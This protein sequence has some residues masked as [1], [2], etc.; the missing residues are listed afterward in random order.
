MKNINIQFKVSFLF[1]LVL[2]F[3]GCNEDLKYD[4]EVLEVPIITDFSPK[5][6]IAGTEIKITGENLLKIDTIYIGGELS[7]I[8][9]RINSRGLIAEATNKSKT[10]TIKIKGP[11]GEAKS[12]ETFQVEYQTPT[13]GE[14]PT[15]AQQNEEI[16]IE[17]THLTA[18]LD[19]FFGTTESKIVNQGIDYITVIVPFFEEDKVDIIMT[20]N[21]AEGV[22]E[23]STEG[24]PFELEGLIP[25]ITHFDAGAEN[26]FNIVLSG[27]NLDL[28]SQVMFGEKEG[29]ILEQDAERI[30]V[31]VP[32]DFTEDT[33]I[34]LKLIYNNSREILLTENFKVS[35]KPVYYWDNITIYA[36]SEDNED[37]FFNA[38]TGEIYSPCLYSKVKSRIDFFI[39][40]GKTNNTF[41]LNNPNNSASQTKTFKCNG[42]NLPAEKMTNIVKFRVLS[43]TGVQGEF[44]KKVKEKSI[45]EL[46]QQ[47]IEETGIAAAGTSAPRFQGESNAFGLDDV[48]MFQKFSSDG[49]TPEK[50]GF[51]EIVSAVSDDTKSSLT[52]NCYF[53]K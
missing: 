31:T 11:N 44:Y 6:G 8:K 13:I 7:K 15:I 35:Y 52:F 41:Q 23:V 48:L 16:Y 36:Q 40:W 1:L 46:S 43:R 45:E 9:Y 2:M 27:A 50:V 51:I 39:T 29:Q 38:M 32:A 12:S 20:Y 10:G 5:S 21:T 24:E 49:T 37:N 33:M 3:I 4:K 22:K 53:E 17:G 25:T 30:L 34:A 28:I 18:V 26:G 14:F 47:M 19:V 42:E